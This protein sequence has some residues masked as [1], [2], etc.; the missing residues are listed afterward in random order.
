MITKNYIQL[1]IITYLI[2]TVRNLI[3][4]QSAGKPSY[5]QHPAS[6]IQHQAITS[7][8]KKPVSNQV[9]EA[10]IKTCISH[11]SAERILEIHHF[12]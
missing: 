6:N 4:Q 9:I 10:S 11:R 8:N 1:L 7:S 2:L 12:P 5:I 3:I